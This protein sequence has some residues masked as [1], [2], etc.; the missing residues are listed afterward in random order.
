MDPSTSQVLSYR[1]QG[2][3]NAF[4]AP[5]DWLATTTEK[6]DSFRQLYIDG[7]IYALTADNVVKHHGGKVQQFALQ[8]PP[9]NGDLRPGHDYRLIAGSGDAG[10]GRLYVYDAKWN[11]V[12]VFDKANGSYVGQWQS[13]SSATPMKDVSGVA[14]VVPQAPSGAAAATADPLLAQP[15]GRHAE[16]AQRRRAVSRRE[17]VAGRERPHRRNR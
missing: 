13:V 2:A 1:P 17:P 4:S 15:H 9:D 11:R 8:T 10:A 7:D 3:G 12:V 6:V 16:R 5:T 14:L